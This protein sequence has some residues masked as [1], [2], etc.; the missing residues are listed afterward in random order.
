MGWKL[1]SVIIQ[2]KSDQ[3]D[4]DILRLIGFSDLEPIH[5]QPYEIAIYPEEGEVYIGR[6]K[7]TIIIA[8]RDLVDSNLSSDPSQMEKQ[9]MQLFPEVEI[10]SVSLH[11]A[12]NHWG[13][14]IVKGGRKIRVKAGDAD[15]GTTLDEGEPLE[16]ERDLLTQSRIDRDGKRI[17]QL[18][19]NVYNEDQVGENFVFNFFSRYTGVQ[20]DQDDD[21]LFDSSFAGFRF[22]VKNLAQQQVDFFSE[23][24]GKYTLGR[25]YARSLQG[26][27][28]GFTLKI[29]A[30][31]GQIT[32]T[33]QDDN[34]LGD[35]PASIHGVMLDSLIWFIKQYPVSYVINDEGKTN[36]DVS[37]P[38]PTIAYTGLYDTVT[39]SY[40]GIWHIENTALWGE[41]SMQKK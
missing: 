3:K 12:I 10:C 2:S 31:E 39:N 34:K 38:S 24:L 16:Q 26:T 32:G 4:E 15:S 30:N 1:S 5:N 28:E 29:E 19:S 25:G 14:S 27:G 11:S 7:D 17:Y 23:W 35:A 18:G 20:L 36:K 22:G 8:G 13:F 40:Q 33:C 41:W 6:Y 21:L 37:K 9:L